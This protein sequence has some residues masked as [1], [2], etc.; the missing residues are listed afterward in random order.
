[1]RRS[2]FVPVLFVPLLI[3]A[4]QP[5][6]LVNWPVGYTLNPGLPRH[7][8]ASSGNGGLMSARLISSAIAFGLDVFGP[9]AVE[10][11]DPG[12]GQPLW[13]CSL[14]DS[15]TVESGAVDNSG[16]VYVAGRFMA[17]I[18]LC[19]GSVIGHTG[20]GLDVDLYLMK[21]DPTGAPVWSR[22]LSIADPQASMV[23]AL[24]VAPN[25]DLWYATSDFFLGKVARVDALGND[26]EVRVIDGAK[27]IG[28]M[29]FAPS[30]A[31]Y[32][33]GA[34][35]S[36]GF[37]FGG[38]AT[39]ASE[40]YT[41]FVL[42]YTAAGAGDWVEF[43]H[44]ITFQQPSLAV[45]DFGNAHVACGIFDTTSWGG[46]S[47]NGPD[48]V[49]SIFLAKADSTGQFLWGVESDPQG[50]VITGDLDQ[51]ARSFLGLDDQGNVY[52]TGTLRGLVDWGGGVVSDGLTM[53]VRTQTIVAFGP[54]GAPLWAS[55]SAPTGAFTQTMS[56]TSV[57]N[58]TIYFSSH[59][60]GQYD[61][62]PLSV[63]GGGQQAYVI[64]RIGGIGTGISAPVPPQELSAW[65]VPTNT[66]VTV[67]LDGSARMMATL[68][69]MTGQ[70][71]RSITLSPGTNVLDLTDLE[72]G[73]Y[74]LR[75]D[76]GR[77]C[78]LAKE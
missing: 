67:G 70:Q 47:F 25:G 45:D 52:L 33:S 78:I 22:N 20:V 64:G 66:K 50:G 15:L 6:W 21:F 48:W 55:T 17:P 9:C 72:A 19:D 44:D 76:N 69:S 65:P 5:D 13:T 54:N 39:Q 74:L 42:R 75:A 3:N 57:D 29:D 60:S 46:I 38:L 62:T 40:Q 41:M 1:M 8:L 4:Q 37:A 73:L 2:L 71:V 32:V 35:Q 7:V 56:L 61:F 68:F 36:G 12:T 31:L 51:A 28:G 30:G 24:A 34:A 43:A 58:G 53:G 59:V 49:S 27:M 10:R 16:N 77:I 23:P 63:N 14:S 26:V 18:A 11:L